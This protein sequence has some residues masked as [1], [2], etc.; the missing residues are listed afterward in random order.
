MAERE[1]LTTREAQLGRIAHLA[2]PRLPRAAGVAG[3][4]MVVHL[5]PAEVMG[6]AVEAAKG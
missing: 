1:V 6:V 5:E 2:Q 3:L 4:Q